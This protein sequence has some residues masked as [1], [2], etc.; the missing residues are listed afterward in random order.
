MYLECK[1]ILF[2]TEIRVILQWFTYVYTS[3]VESL[4]VIFL[5]TVNLLVTIAINLLIQVGNE[6]SG[7]SHY[8]PCQVRITK[9]KA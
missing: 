8:C 4:T 2:D 7:T 9:A 3:I 1:Y 6:N 5:C